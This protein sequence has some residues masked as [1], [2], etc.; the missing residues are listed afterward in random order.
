MDIEKKEK[1]AYKQ[2]ENA[3][4]KGKNVGGREGKDADWLMRWYCDKKRKGK[5]M[6]KKGKEK[7]KEKERERKVKDKGKER[8]RKGKGKEP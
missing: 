8:E 5:E 3:G 2:C 7:G 6:G 4:V 1:Y